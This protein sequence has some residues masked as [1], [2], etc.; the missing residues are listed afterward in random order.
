MINL[1]KTLSDAHLALDS[2]GVSHALI[3]GFALAV[4]GYHRTT[5]DIDLL[6]DGTKKDAIKKIFLSQGYSLRFESSEVLQFSGPGFI[7]ILLANR[8]LSQE[9]LKRAQLNVS[10]NVYVL[11][12]EDIIGL[13]IQA[14]KNDPSRELQDKADIQRLLALP[15]LDMDI[16]K[17]YAD[18]FDE[19]SV[20]K[21]LKGS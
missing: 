14:Y 17:K 7:D 13:K 18:L 9:M 16:I 5:S 12:A 4:Y 3:G 6:A 19:W 2:E 11:K 10:L 1:R 15:D 8:P 21:K 20:I